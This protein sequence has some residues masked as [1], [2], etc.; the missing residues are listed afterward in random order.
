MEP[1]HSPTL[2]RRERGAD[3]GEVLGER[4][5]TVCARFN[6]VSGNRREGGDNSA[7]FLVWQQGGRAHSVHSMCFCTC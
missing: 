6:L 4:A 3:D 1:R 7:L 5:G 2:L